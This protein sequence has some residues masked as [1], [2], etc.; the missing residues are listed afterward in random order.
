MGPEINIFT[1]H[2]FLIFRKRKWRWLCR[3]EWNSCQG[4]QTNNWPRSCLTSLSVCLA[5]RPAWPVAAGISIVVES[6]EKNCMTSCLFFFLLTSL[7][8]LPV[9]LCNLLPNQHDACVNLFTASD[10]AWTVYSQGRYNNDNGFWKTILF[11]PQL[12]IHSFIMHHLNSTGF[13]LS[14]SCA[15]LGVFNKFRCFFLTAS[16][17]SILL[18]ASE[19]WTMN[20][21]WI[22]K[23]AE[24]CS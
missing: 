17:C 20:K 14:P 13:D 7:W 5:A 6:A 8:V 22:I 18:Y 16:K 21:E 23:A 4:Q 10:D 12:L 19:A 2:F 15:I 3:S 11:Y 24:V 1:G 9:N